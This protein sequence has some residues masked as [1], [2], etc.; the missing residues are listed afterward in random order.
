MRDANFSLSISG[1][2]DRRGR[3]FKVKQIPHWRVV[4]LRGS[5]KFGVFREGKA[6][7]GGCG[8]K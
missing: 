3:V 1:K 2:G 8:I 4:K 5:G 7:E 6:S